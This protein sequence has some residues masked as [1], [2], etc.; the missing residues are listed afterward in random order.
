ML[1]VLNEIPPCLGADITS[2]PEF[3][4]KAQAPEPRPALA[5]GLQQQQQSH[6]TA[7]HYEQMR[8]QQLQL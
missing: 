5:Q 2:V 3:C 4:A 1:A 8:A 7:T 6:Y